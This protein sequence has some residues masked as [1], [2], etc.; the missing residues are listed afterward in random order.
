MERVH[1]CN[2]WPKWQLANEPAFLHLRHCAIWPF[3]T[4]HKKES[5]LTNRMSNNTA[6]YSTYVYNSDYDDYC[7]VGRCACMTG[8]LVRVSAWCRTPA[9]P[10]GTA[11]SSTRCPS[12]RP[13]TRG[14]RPSVFAGEWHYK[15]STSLIANLGDWLLSLTK[16]GYQLLPLAELGDQLLSLVKLGDRLLSL[17]KLGD[18]LLSLA[19]LDLRL[20]SLAKLADRL[21]SL[22][23]LGGR[24]LSLAK[25]YLWLLSLAELGDRLISLVKFGDWLL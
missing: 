7:W 3:L 25:L 23:K 12:A 22:A 14:A 16:L 1:S 9:P 5:T 13:T 15:K 6:G 2:M 11:A 4:M 10:W 8:P 20:L 17:A 21:L 24:L 18:R 19:K